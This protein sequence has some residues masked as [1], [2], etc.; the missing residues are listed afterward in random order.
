MRMHPSRENRSLYDGDRYRSCTLTGDPTSRAGQIL[1]RL[2]EVGQVHPVRPRVLEVGANRGEHMSFVRH[3]W[4]E[5]LLLDLTPPDPAVL[6]SFAED[7]QFVTG[8]A[9]S[10]PFPDGHFDRTIMTC[11]LHHVEHPELALMELRRV[12]KPGGRISVLLPTDP[13]I[14]YRVVRWLTSGAMARRADRYSEERLSH[15]REHRNHYASL[16]TLLRHVLRF[17]EVHE[18]PF[19]LGLPSWNLNLVTVIQ[20][21]RSDSDLNQPPGDPVSPGQR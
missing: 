5:Y 13:G 2:L 11:V 21:T 8:D 18:R 4:D 15:A 1:H 17:D 3:R 6:A 10:L 9:H 16:L 12:T 20:A 14:A 19:P 7:V